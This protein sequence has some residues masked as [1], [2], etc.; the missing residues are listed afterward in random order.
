M[1]L[2]I[3]DIVTCGE[4]YNTRKN[5]V[6]GVLGFR[7][8]ERPM[9]LQL[10]GNC[11]SDLAGRSFRFEVR[12]TRLHDARS[13]S[14]AEIDEQRIAWIQVGSPGTMTAARMVRAFDCS[15]EEFLR[16][17][18]LGEQPPTEWKRCLYLEWYSQNGRVVVE[19]ADP[20]IEFLDGLP[21]VPPSQEIDENSDDPFASGD[22]EP[23]VSGPQITAIEI[24]ADGNTHVY[25]LS[26]GVEEHGDVVDNDDPY[27]LFPDDLEAAIEASSSDSEWQPE[28]TDET[29]KLWAQWDE[30]LDGKKDVPICTLFDPPLKLAPA[31]R[32]DDEQVRI[33]LSVLISRLAMHGIAL[34][35]CEHA[36]P[37]SAYRYLVEDILVREFAHPKLPVTNYVRH[38]SMLDDC[39]ECQAD[40]ERRYAAKHP[41]S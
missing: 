4:I 11:D 9:S 28:V 13:T 12:E 33:A 30:I 16:R 10:T 6:H 24:D 22:L 41:E 32:L 14:E 38:F 19:I 27:G 39:P 17:T 29:R 25:D 3:G 35:M 23:P 26:D 5:S 40:F 18:R 7:D 15:I 2:R 20:I 1:A 31:D 37:R 21:D 8:C 36:T 34:D